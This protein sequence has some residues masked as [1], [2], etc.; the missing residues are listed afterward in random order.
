MDPIDT[1]ISASP[2]ERQGALS[3]LRDILRDILVPLGYE[4]CISYGMIGYVVPY[5]LY[6]EGYHCKPRLPL[7]FINLANQKH[8]IH[9]YHMG[10]WA[11]PEVLEWWKDA[12]AKQNIGKL[13]M[14]KG[15]IRFKNL[16]K[17]PYDLI[18][19]LVKKISATE[20]IGLYETAYRSK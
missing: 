19:E 12:Y 8:G 13:D 10:M 11:S 6:P 20:W 2:I 1:Y 14:G 5:S 9:L 3:K 4:E 15:C 7:P 17:I 16:E 18:R